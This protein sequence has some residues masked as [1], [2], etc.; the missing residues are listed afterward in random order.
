MPSRVIITGS[1]RSG[2]ATGRA[3]SIGGAALAPLLGQIENWLE[4]AVEGGTRAVFRQRL[5][6]IELAKAATRA[7]QRQRLVGPEGIEVPNAFTI[8]L[9]PTDLAELAKYQGGLE[10]RLV[11]YL[12]GF[13]D[14]RGLVPVG[15][16]TVELVADSTVRRRTVRVD[17]QMD[18]QAAGPT[19]RPAPPIG[20][21]E[22]LPRIQRPVA[23]GPLPEQAVL[24][25]LE[26]GR[27]V[28]LADGAVRI[29]RALDNDLVI[30]DSRVSRYHAQ[31]VPDDHGPIVRDLG[32][33]NG[34]AV[35]GRVIAEDRL[36][37]G[38]TLSL[39][40]YQIGVRIGA[41]ARPGRR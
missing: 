19:T 31:I 1:D 21:T 23:T 28:S 29:G 32:S 36:A 26:D 24:L 35:A 41:S 16:V 12:T 27:Q 17:A 39:G 7:M 2:S 11:R 8:A 4:R 33:T 13:A 9:H 6:P 14:E 34:T 5:Q 25:V 30:A 15:P 22:L 40:G 10:T 3:S 20:A 18:D 37:H 38:D